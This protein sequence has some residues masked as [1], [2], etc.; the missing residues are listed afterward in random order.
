MN[1]A[2]DEMKQAKED[3]YFYRQE[4]EALERLKSKKA[5]G[6]PKL[7]P[8]TGKPMVEMN[9]GGVIIDKCET[10]GGVWLDGGELEQLLAFAR[11][12][13]SGSNW[14]KRFVST[15]FGTKK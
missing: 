8:V 4:K 12:E 1:D 2:W 5:T 14:T 9:I 6:Q 3:E 11:N 15:L 13:A 7:S 10:S